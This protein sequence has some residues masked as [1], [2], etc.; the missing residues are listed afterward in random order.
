MFYKFCGEPALVGAGKKSSPHHIADGAR[1]KAVD[2]VIR[3]YYIYKKI[4]SMVLPYR[5]YS[6]LYCIFTAMHNY[7]DRT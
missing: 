6:D 2:A 3:S 5:K 4:L 1:H 7:L